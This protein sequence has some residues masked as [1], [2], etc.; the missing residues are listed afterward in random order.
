MRYKMICFFIFVRYFLGFVTVIIAVT[1]LTAYQKRFR[2]S[3]TIVFIPILRRIFL[4]R[5]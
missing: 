2:F 1:K 5:N 4:R 3:S